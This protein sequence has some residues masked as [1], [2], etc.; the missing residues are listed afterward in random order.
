MEGI[1]SRVFE[2]KKFMWDGK[3]YQ[4]E[5]EAKA[6]QEKYSADEFETQVVSENE[7]FFVFTRRLVKEVV[8][9]GEPM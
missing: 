6:A 2:G 8:V 9:E 5:Q 7:L 1:V 4:A 3:E